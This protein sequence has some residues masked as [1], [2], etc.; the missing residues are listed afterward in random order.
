M[1]KALKAFRDVEEKVETKR[2]SE[3]CSLLVAFDGWYQ[4]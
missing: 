1:N 2:N 4:L 3:A